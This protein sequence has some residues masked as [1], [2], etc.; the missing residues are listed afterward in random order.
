MT[1][2]LIIEILAQDGY[3]T[4]N[5]KMLKKIGYEN[6]LILS[7][8]CDKYKFHQKEFYCTLDH[9]AD[10][11][12]LSKFL[13]NKCFKECLLKNNLITITKRGIPCHNYYD[14][15]FD[16]LR[17]LL[18]DGEKSSCQ[19]CSQ[20]EVKSVDNK[21]SKDL[22]TRSEMCSQQEVKSVH[23]YNNNSKNKEQEQR[24]KTENKNKR[25][26]QPKSKG[27]LDEQKAVVF[28]NEDLEE[29]AKQDL[30]Q[31]AKQKKKTIET[32]EVHE[33]DKGINKFLDGMKEEI[34]ACLR[35]KEKQKLK[36]YETTE[37]QE[38]ELEQREEQK[39]QTNRTNHELNPLGETGETETEK[40]AETQRQISLA[41]VQSPPKPPK[42]PTPIPNALTLQAITN[43]SLKQA[44]ENFLLH[45][46]QIK[47]PIKTQLQFDNWL[48]RLRELSGN[49]GNLAIKIIETSI[50]NG[51]QGIFS[52]NTNT[53][54][55][56]NT[57]NY[58]GARPKER[59]KTFEAQKDDNHRQAL[60]KKYEFLAKIYGEII[61]RDPEMY[62]KMWKED[63][64]KQGGGLKRG[65]QEQGGGGQEERLEE[66]QKTSI[67]T[68]Q[69]IT[70]Q[71]E[72]AQ[73][74][75]K[76]RKD[77]LEQKGLERQGLT[78]GQ[79]ERQEEEYLREGY[80]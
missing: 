7:Y 47:K 73:D 69:A 76:W 61:Y 11:T 51:W 12:G 6:T 77:V 70:E 14:I 53:G 80:G 20:Q 62:Y 78:G 3:L 32:I 41:R 74:E 55:Y 9:I 25:G 21:K 60:L 57:T 64:L 56:G 46:Q 39:L 13:I 52:E 8:L 15:N 24:I 22:I 45:R 36:T 5:K 72:I 42:P 28:E 43:P 71:R 37:T 33:T 65:E 30:Q 59:P 34:M 49:N 19:I 66:K 67:L 4:L 27:H 75:L 26:E 68:N 1:K 35:E 48:K 17:E 23:F 79:E 58:G 18:T 31:K 16:G 50:A 40:N 2:E 54:N 38:Q 29:K 63:L 44:V 10:D